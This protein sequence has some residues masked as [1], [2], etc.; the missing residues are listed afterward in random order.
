MLAQIRRVV[1]AADVL[2]VDDNSPDGTGELADQIAAV[3]PQVHVLHRAGKEGLGRAYQAGFGVALSQPDVET[4]VQMD[5]DFSHD[6]A[7]I[8]TLISIVEDGADL[9]I[10]SR[11]VR[12]GDTPGWGRRRRLIS[13]GGSL[14]ART[15]LGMPYHD[16]TGGFKAWRRELL[17]RLDVNH[18]QANGYGFQIETTWRAHNLGARIVETPIT[19]RDR[20]A[21]NSKMSQAIMREALMLVLR[22]RIAPRPVA[23]PA[24]VRSS[25]VAWASHSA[26]PSITSDPS[27][28]AVRYS[29]VDA[30]AP[31]VEQG[32][33]V[34]PGSRSEPGGPD[35]WPP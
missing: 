29:H 14:F 4:I 33:L 31:Q 30:G 26:T 16:L 8:A 32:K 6:P 34:M 12:G 1:P 13:R 17:E 20:F 28:S 15:V 27:I 2:V 22:L 11:Y 10:G 3:D 5:C 24:A 25:S 35:A 9:V 19:F 23:Y 7:A 18:L 21:G